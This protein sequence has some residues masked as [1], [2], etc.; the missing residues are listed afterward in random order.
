[1]SLNILANILKRGEQKRILKLLDRV[2]NTINVFEPRFSTMTDDELKQCMDDFKSRYKDGEDLDSLLPETFSVIRE[3][4]KRVL[5]MRHFDVQIAGGIVLHEGNIAE[6]K[7]GEG[8]TLVATLP[9]ILNSI[10]GKQCHIITVNDYLAKRDSQWMGPV[11]EFLGVTVGLIQAHMDNPDRIEAYKADVVYGTNSEFGFDYLRDNMAIDIADKVQRGNDFAIVDEVDSILIDEARTPLIISGAP[12]S[13]SAD[14]NRVNM[15]IKDMRKKILPHEPVTP[16]EKEEEAQLEKDYDF[17]AFEKEHSVKETSSGQEKLAKALGYNTEDFFGSEYGEKGAHR[18]S[19]QEQFQILKIKN[20]FKQSLTAHSLY[21]AD[22]DYIVNDGEVIIIDEFTGRQMIGRRYSDGLHQAIE[23]KEKVRIG[24]ENQTLATITLQNYFRMYEKLAGMTGT[25]STEADE[26][27]HIYELDTVVVPSNKTLKRIDFPDVIYKNEEAKFKALVNEIEK[28]HTKGQPLLI[29]TVS[30]EKNE[31][32]SKLLKRR[33]IKHELLN[34]KNHE[35]EAEIIA[36]AGHKGAITVATNMAGRGVDI[37]LGGNPES[38]TREEMIKQG[39]DVDGYL[40]FEMTE[41]ELKEYKAAY[42]PIFEKYR[43][44]TDKEHPEVISLGGLHVIGTERHESRRIDNQLRG[45]AG[46][47]GDTGSSQFYLSCED[48]LMRLFA[49]DRIKNI[50]DTFN[51]PEDEPIEHK[52]ISKSI[53]SA[54]KQV[55]SQNF[56]IRK[57]VL[58]YDDVMNKQ[59]E[60]IYGERDKVLKGEKLGEM[61][62]TFLDEV[63]DSIVAEHANENIAP[64]EW[65]LDDL[66]NTLNEMYT[67]TLSKNNFDIETLNYFELLDSVKEDAEKALKTKKEEFGEENNNILRAVLLQVIDEHWKSHLTELDYFREGVYLRAF[68]QRD[69]LV[70]FKSE[71]YNMFQKL[72]YHIKEDSLKLY[73]NAQIVEQPTSMLEEAA[74][75]GWSANSSTNSVNIPD[76]KSKKKVGRNDPCPCGSGKKYKRC[77]GA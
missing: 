70:E 41:E 74:Y 39:F 46:R 44:I 27:K 37:I 52:M 28:R 18:L 56:S 9:A 8:K 1:M 22:R 61:A 73:F 5:K 55:E 2:E 76:T 31:Y 17:I 30:I 24:E 57:H 38:L 58:E 4:S 19:S 60:V 62:E 67:S 47:Q 68:A 35:R 49:G 26:F 25:A 64:E 33:G 13:A 71:A 11:Y 69:P 10:A 59:R 14:Y 20:I 34:A 23:A 53:E 7:T 77:C 16:E 12:E 3:A 63:I 29:G 32:L 50:M 72:I 75:S 65:N 43:A 66:L 36:Q 45:R 48:D 6:M 54:Q 15:I 40:N 51:I 42:K 21:L